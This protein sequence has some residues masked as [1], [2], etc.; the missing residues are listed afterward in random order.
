MNLRDE[1]LKYLRIFT[2]SDGVISV[3]TKF[4]QQEDEF[5]FRLLVLSP[6]NHYVLEQLIFSKRIEFGHC[7]VSLLMTILRENYWILKIRKI[8]KKVIN[9]CTVCKRYSSE[10][11]EVDESTLPLD[12]VQDV[13]IF[14][15]IGVDLC[16]V[17]FSV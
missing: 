10:P 14:E 17:V 9:K 1:K 3:R 6:S 2:N 13:A 5:N 16:S 7:G 11:L 15:I 12:R 4:F 8:V